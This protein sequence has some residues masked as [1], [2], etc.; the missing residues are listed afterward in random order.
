MVRNILLVAGW[1]THIASR[2]S[3]LDPIRSAFNQPFAAPSTAEFAFRREGD[4]TAVT[5][6]T[7]GRG[8]IL[9]QAVWLVP[10]RDRL[11]GGHSEQGL[12]NLESIAE[13][14]ARK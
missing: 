1:P 12:G 4:Q 3:E 2:A 7:S 5:G 13:S 14:A 6:S 11:T 8:N 10:H 9:E